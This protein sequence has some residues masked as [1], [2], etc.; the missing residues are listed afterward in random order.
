MNKKIL[1]LDR[2][3]YSIRFRIAIRDNLLSF[4][5]NIFL[6]SDWLV[7]KFLRSSTLAHSLGVRITNKMTSRM[8]CTQKQK[9][10]KN[11]L[12]LISFF[13]RKRQKKNV[14]LPK[15]KQFSSAEN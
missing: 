8:S 5:I 3:R 2:S 4:G 6:V 15:L 9:N 1:F 10:H 13:E 12:L 11:L 7:N 14:K